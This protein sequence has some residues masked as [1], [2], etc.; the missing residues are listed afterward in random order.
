MG[1]SK[2]KAAAK[3]TKPGQ[4]GQEDNWKDRLEQ[5]VKDKIALQ[6]KKARGRSDEL[7][8]RVHRT[9]TSNTG[10]PYDTSLLL[11]QKPFLMS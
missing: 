10:L 8:R 11:I 3:C 9:S 6:V 5:A 1:A 2:S 7:R 4:L